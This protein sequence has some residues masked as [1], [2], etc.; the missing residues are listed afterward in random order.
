MTFAIAATSAFLTLILATPAEASC[1]CKCIHSKMHTVCRDPLDISVCGGHCSGSTCIGFCQPY[2]PKG[3]IAEQS[4][5]Q[6]ERK[7]YILRRPVR[8]PTAIVEKSL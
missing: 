6:W 1:E 3:G 7:N 2:Q 5:L 4:R 8:E